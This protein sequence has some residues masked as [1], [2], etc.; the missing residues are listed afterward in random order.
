[1]GSGE[2][3]VVVGEGEVVEGAVLSIPHG[4]FCPEH[5]V[6]SVLSA[7]FFHSHSTAVGFQGDEERCRGTVSS[8]TRT[9][10]CG[11]LSQ[12]TAQFSDALAERDGPPGDERDV[13]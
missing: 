3:V 11:R 4:Q 13:M 8:S 5:P 1:M 7:W 10:R 9:M 6:L 2:A 12:R